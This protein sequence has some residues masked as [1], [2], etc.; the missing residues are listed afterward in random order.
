MPTKTSSSK[1]RQMT[2]FAATEAGEMPAYLFYPAAD[3]AQDRIWKTTIEKWGEP[4]AETYIRGLHAH[5]QH[6]CKARV[7]WRSLPQALVVRGNLA[8]RAYLSRY[9]PHYVLFRELSGA[10]IGISRIQTG[11]G[12]WRDRGG[13]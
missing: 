7:L 13:Q 12:S 1:C 4:Q 10:R 8:G 5:L 11:T 9:E 6:L 2:S 3:L